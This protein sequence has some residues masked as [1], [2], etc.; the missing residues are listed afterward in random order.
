MPETGSD[1]SAEFSCAQQAST[2]TDKQGV[3][4][5]KIVK[6]FRSNTTA[7][8]CSPLHRAQF[9]AIAVPFAR[10]Y[11]ISKSPASIT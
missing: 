3:T 5:Q 6:L 2:E 4:S 1:T 7:E 8:N 9:L 10:D 11:S